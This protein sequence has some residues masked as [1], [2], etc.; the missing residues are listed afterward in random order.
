MFGCGGVSEKSGA[1]TP[2]EFTFTPPQLP[3]MIKS[4][5]EAAIW[6]LQNWWSELS[7][8]DSTAVGSDGLKMAYALWAQG[9]HRLP[10][11][12]AAGMIVGELKKMENHPDMHAEFL[13][14]GEGYFGDPTSEIR[15]DTLFLA[16]LDYVL[17]SDKVSELE[18]IRPTELKKLTLQNQV[19]SIAPDL[20]WV[21]VDRKAGSVYG[22]R[23]EMTI[24]MF[25]TPG[26]AS[27][28]EIFMGIHRDPTIQEL[29]ESGKMRVVALYTDGD[30]DAWEGYTGNIPPYWENGFVGESFNREKPYAVRATPSI[31]MMDKN[32]RIMLKDGVNHLS[33]LEK[34]KG[35]SR[36]SH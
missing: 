29:V 9:L 32:R 15:Q 25:Y 5:Q 30:K 21:G 27:C 16:L 23:A 14:L 31:F 17:Q 10:R 1:T 33:V 22:K 12:Q 24:L 36:N 13:R 35:T 26:C 34:L 7:P 8:Q 3:L 20:R 6:M 4:E 18:K 2:K 11:E 19:G 28:A